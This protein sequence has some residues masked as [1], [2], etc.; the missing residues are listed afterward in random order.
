[1][2]IDTLLLHHPLHLGLDKG[3]RRLHTIQ[4]CRFWLC[5]EVSAYTPRLRIGFLVFPLLARPPGAKKLL[6]LLQ[7]MFQMPTAIH[8]PPVVLPSHRLGRR[9]RCKSLGLLD[10]PHSFLE[11]L[12]ILRHDGRGRVLLATSDTPHLV[13]SNSDT[14]LVELPDLAPRDTLR[15]GLVLLATVVVLL[16]PV[17]HSSLASKGVRLRYVMHALRPLPNTT[18]FASFCAK[19]HVRCYFHRHMCHELRTARLTPPDVADVVAFRTNIF[20]WILHV[21][22]SPRDIFDGE[23]LPG[24][25]LQIAIPLSQHTLLLEPRQPGLYEVA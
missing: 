9:A 18:T 17:A 14:R 21:W 11:S 3:L 16:V 6:L 23:L 4:P 15:L 7:R 2:E 20:I 24:I 22:H 25:L 5:G 13:P 1:M 10:H 12:Q 19:L 8:P